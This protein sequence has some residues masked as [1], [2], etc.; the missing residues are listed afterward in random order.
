MTPIQAGVLADILDI[1]MCWLKL[2]QEAE[3][4]GIWYRFIN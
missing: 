2:K 4:G 1:K 3:N